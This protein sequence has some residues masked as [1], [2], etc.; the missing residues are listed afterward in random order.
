MPNMSYCRFENTNADLADCVQALD[1]TIKEGDKYFDNADG[2]KEEFNEYENSAIRN[3][4]ENCK[5]FVE[6]FEANGWEED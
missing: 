3:L 1:D 2:E 6:R 5:E 4:Y